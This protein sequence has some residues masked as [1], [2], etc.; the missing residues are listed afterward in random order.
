MKTLMVLLSL[1]LTLSVYS[2][3]LKMYSRIWSMDLT[4]ELP[5]INNKD[6][7]SFSVDIVKMSK[8]N[9]NEDT[10]YKIL[11]DKFNEFRNDYGVTP[12]VESPTITKRCKT[13]SKSL[14]KKFKHSKDGHKA[15]VCSRFST[16]MLGE[17][18]DS[19]E[20]N[21]FFAECLFDIF[22]YSPKHMEILLLNK[23]NIKYGF[24]FTIVGDMIETSTAYVV[25]Q[26]DY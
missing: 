20:I 1:I 8:L 26:A 4:G 16:L 25:I 10:V 18:V 5:K 12:T 13:Y 7:N 3:E 17:V 14:P 9:I 2:Q 6:G 24:G 11:L 23:E 15:E 19:S 21:T 22:A